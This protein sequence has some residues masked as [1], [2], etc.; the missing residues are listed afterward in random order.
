V[1]AEHD[2]P[3]VLANEEALPHHLEATGVGEDGTGPPHERVEAARGLY[4]LDAG[5]H[6]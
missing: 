3:V 2:R 5:S 1:V 4:G 6:Q